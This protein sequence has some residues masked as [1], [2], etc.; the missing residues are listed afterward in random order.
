[1]QIS[2][3]EARDLSEAWFRCVCQVLNDGREYTIERGSYAGEKR[4][5]LDFV[6]I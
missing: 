4:K 3:I 5:E 2:F 6:V 1:M